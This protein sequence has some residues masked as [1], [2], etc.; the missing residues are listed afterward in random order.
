MAQ[1]SKKKE[2]RKTDIFFKL[3]LQ[4][5]TM[6]LVLIL[7]VMFGFLF[8]YS[9]DALK[10]FGLKFFINTKWDPVTENFGALSAV[11]GTIMSSIIALIIAVP[12]SLGIAIFLSELATNKSKIIF[13]F[14]IEMLAA[15]PSII[16]GLWGIFVIAPI[17]RNNIQPI[18]QN[19][20]GFL[21]IF[22]GPAYGIGLFTAGFILSIMIIPTIA[23]ISKEIF[24][25]LPKDLREAAL[26]LG[27]TKWETIKIA[28]LTS[29]KNGICGAIMLGLGRALGE[30]MAVAMVIGN[31]P[32]ISISLFEPAQTMASVIANEY[33]EAVSDIHVSSLIAIGLGLFLITLIINSIAYLIINYSWP[34]KWTL[35]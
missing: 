31:K 6:L 35:R 20:L 8:Y 23:S 26:A 5:V 22:S 1:N 14:F 13:G 34:Q 15:V 25:S 24:S 27:A 7:A 33:S 18:I 28:V 19:F 3:I 11:Y 2:I 9:L 30:T 10:V 12:L 17:F 21:P 4:S 32:K 29:A 16:Y